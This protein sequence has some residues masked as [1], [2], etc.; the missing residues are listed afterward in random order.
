MEKLFKSGK[1]KSIGISNWNISQI[2]QLLKYAEIPPAINQ[3]EIN[4]FF[5]N[6][7][8]IKF[9]TGHKILPVGYT[10]LA[11]MTSEVISKNADLLAL[12]D[13]KG[14]TLAQILIAWGIKRGYALVPKSAN[15]G[16]IKSNFELIE[17]SDEEFQIVSNVT[18]G[19][20]GRMVN[21]TIFGFKHFPEEKSS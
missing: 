3:I 15:E 13:K 12:A 19:K 21:P 4:I 18:E 11:K 5:P 14:A 10:P 17:L 20:R 16:R 1:A 2:E 6:T 9:C 7:E 8:L